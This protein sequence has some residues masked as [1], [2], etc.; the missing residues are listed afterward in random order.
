M[1]DIGK[2]NDIVGSQPGSLVKGYKLP[3]GM[4]NRVTHPLNPDYQLPG[5]NEAAVN[6]PYGVQGSSMTNLKKVNDQVSEKKSSK[7]P[8]SAAAPSEKP[9][10]ERK[11]PSNA[12]RRPSVPRLSG[13]GSKVGSK[14]ASAKTRGS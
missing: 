3:E 5:R 4:V 10:T 2:N 9:L 12:S 7:P 11:D 6:D 13:T 1:R 14:P 8:L